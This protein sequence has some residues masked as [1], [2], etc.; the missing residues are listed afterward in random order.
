MAK[1]SRWAGIVLCGL[2]VGIVAVIVDS[3]P[4][5]F[6]SLFLLCIPAGSWLFG[7]LT[8]AGIS[9]R[10]IASPP[11]TVGDEMEIPIEISNPGISP[12]F[13]VVASLRL[14]P[15][16]GP[17]VDEETGPDDRAHSSAFLR[18]R[19]RSRS[20]ASAIAPLVQGRGRTRCV[21]RVQ[22]YRRGLHSVGPITLAHDD[23]LRLSSVRKQIPGSH[24]LIVYPRPLGASLGALLSGDRVGTDGI[25]QNRG[26]TDGADFFGLREYR[27]GDE[28]R[29]IHWPTSARAGAL[30]VV[31]RDAFSAVSLLLLIDIT[32]PAGEDAD[33]PLEMLIRLAAQMAEDAAARMSSVTL[34]LF[35]PDGQAAPL[36]FQSMDPVR[37]LDALARIDPSAKLVFQPLETIVRRG[38]SGTSVVLLCDHLDDRIRQVSQICRQLG[39]PG[40]IVVL[41]ASGR[42]ESWLP[43]GN[44][45]CLWRLGH[46]EGYGYHVEALGYS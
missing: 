6:M 19:R 18:R 16:L 45:L 41:E 2:A 17:V 39:C 44:P 10:C 8:L 40:S 30:V 5:Y 1:V 24:E 37:S 29:R 31:E 21:A 3:S 38:A 35:A 4:L 22:T 12:R 34:A 46:R 20:S 13:H 33:A 42:N 26:S 14:P 36:L 43:P 32:A 27:S 11:V 7:A 28:W 25:A 15:D 9:A 23:L